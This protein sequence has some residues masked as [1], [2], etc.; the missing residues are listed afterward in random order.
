MQL[1]DYHF[2]HAA[3]SSQRNRFHAAQQRY[4]K[5]LNHDG[6]TQLSWLQK[7]AAVSRM[8]VTTDPDGHS[9]PR[10][11]G[12]WTS[13]VSLHRNQFTNRQCWRSELVLW[14]THLTKTGL[15]SNHFGVCWNPGGLPRPHRPLGQSKVSTTVKGYRQ[16]NTNNGRT[17]VLLQEPTITL[18]TT[19]I[20]VL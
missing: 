8:K 12:I 11:C 7:R 13:E 6:P 14:A 5:P 19:L 10:R 4:I 3:T 17:F 16:F 15:L 20:T 9:P 18:I 2:A 1:S